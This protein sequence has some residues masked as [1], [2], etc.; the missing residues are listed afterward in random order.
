MKKIL[1]LISMILC[2]LNGCAQEEMSIIIDPETIDKQITFNIITNDINEDYLKK[3]F[4]K[5]EAVRYY[6]ES[7][8]PEDEQSV[9][10]ELIEKLAICNE[11][12]RLGIL[13]DKDAAEKMSKQDYEQLKISGGKYYDSLT[14][15]C[16][17]QNISEEEYMSM[18]ITEGYYKYNRSKLKSY[19][20][21]KIAN[22][23][24]DVSV[25]VQFQEYINK[26][27]KDVKISD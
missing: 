25:D 7:V 22:E 17:E 6:Q 19:F 27:V 9:K 23:K 4:T 13:I 16:Q 24:S 26:I 20:S 10:K 5:K 1:I 18:I 21:E 11:C 14:K 8:L 3:V 2:L 12:D 15:I